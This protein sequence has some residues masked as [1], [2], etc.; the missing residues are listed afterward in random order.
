MKKYIISDIHGDE[1]AYHTIM[2]YL[3][4]ERKQEEVGLYINGDLID[5]GL[6]SAEILLD[7]Y[8][9]QK[10]SLIPIEYLAG[11]HELMMM[12]TFD[13]RKK[14]MYS[15][16]HKIWFRNGGT[17]TDNGLTER[18]KTKDE[19]LEVVD[20]ISNLRIYHKFPETL[21][22]K[23][24]VLVHAACPVKVED[25][26]RVRLKDNTD[27]IY[28]SLWASENNPEIPFRINIGNKDYFTIIGHTPN[29]DPNGYEYHREGDYLNIDGGCSYYVC[30]NKEVDHIPLVEVKDNHLRIITFNH[31]GEII[32][33]NYFDGKRNYPFPE[34]ELEKEKIKVKER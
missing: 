18:L 34:E 7:V 33:G 14:G 2:K 12:E 29:D 25:Q 28:F 19:I 5:R 30:G 10:K 17:V 16:A 6:S 21:N 11:N 1:K 27:S 13:E 31:Q 24:I 15:S 3:E 4:A 20:Y 23:N 9:R 8:E 32:R 22:G 26:K